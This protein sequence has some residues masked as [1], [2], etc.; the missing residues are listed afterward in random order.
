[1]IERISSINTNTPP[2]VTR[3]EKRPA[4][5]PITRSR[6]T[7]R[8]ILTRDIFKLGRDLRPTQYSVALIHFN[9]PDGNYHI[10]DVLT[11]TESQ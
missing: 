11:A 7:K 2:R 4:R 9:L 1:M 8:S 10:S 5:L 6:K 3:L